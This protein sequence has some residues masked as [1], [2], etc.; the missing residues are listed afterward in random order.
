MQQ[1]PLIKTL[2]DS[3]DRLNAMNAFLGD[4]YDSDREVRLDIGAIQGINLIF[5]DA[6]N[7]IYN[8]ITK[9]HDNREFLEQFGNE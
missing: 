3:A 7:G 2:H 9:L 4:E 8:V 1:S 5:N 6:L